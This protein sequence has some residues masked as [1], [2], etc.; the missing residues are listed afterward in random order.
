MKQRMMKAAVLTGPQNIETK[1]VPI[2]TL[3]SGEIEIKVSACGV[4]GSDVHMWKSG[5]GWGRQ[6]LP[7]WLCQK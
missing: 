4:C 6:E 2:P 5:K 7:M 3:K 1:E